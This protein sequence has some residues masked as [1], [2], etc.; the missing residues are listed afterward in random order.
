MKDEWQ[1]P[2]DDLEQR[3]NAV[4]DGELRFLPEPQDKPVH[5]HVNKIH[6]RPTSLDDGWVRLE[7]C[8]ENLDPVAALQIRYHADRIR[9]IRITETRNIGKAGVDKF[10]VELEQI[11]ARARICISA[12]SKALHR[13]NDGFELRNGPFMRKFLDGYYP[14][15]VSLDIDYPEALLKLDSFSPSPEPG[16]QIRLKPGSIKW[17]AYIEGRLFTRFVFKPKTND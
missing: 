4:N 9:N 10:L 8:H 14:M 17:N 15:Q 13:Q 6:I 1:F 12:E 3:I 11:Q 2:E 5:H 16:G 7:Q